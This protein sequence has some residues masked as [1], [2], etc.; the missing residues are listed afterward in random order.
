MRQVRCARRYR[1]EWYADMMMAGCGGS[2]A[3][4]RFVEIH[5]GAEYRCG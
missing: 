4:S 3:S 5:D 2:G 1:F